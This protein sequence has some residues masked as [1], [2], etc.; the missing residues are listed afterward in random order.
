MRDVEL[1]WG[2]YSWSNNL[3]HPTLERLDRVVKND[4]WENTLAVRKLHVQVCVESSGH[5][6]GGPLPPQFA[7]SI[8]ELDQNS[9][10]R[11]RKISYARACGDLLEPLDNKK[12]CMLWK[13]DCTISYRDNLLNQ[14][15]PF[16]LGRATERRRPGAAG[17][18]CENPKNT[19]LHFH[20]QDGRGNVGA[21]LLQQ[22][23][24]TP[25]KQQKVG[26]CHC[27]YFLA[28]SLGM[29]NPY[30]QRQKCLLAVLSAITRNE[31]AEP[32]LATAPKGCHSRGIINTITDESA[33]ARIYRCSLS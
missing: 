9:P 24:L 4:K 20:T 13:Q 31:G 8:L 26:R 18:R 10:P 16:L 25:F 7:W 5:S 28:Q 33:S 30:Q 14:I 29:V 21:I 15:V 12:W 11:G 32:I 19:A 1:N 6:C 22:G 2:K 23:W 27:W 3:S 17:G